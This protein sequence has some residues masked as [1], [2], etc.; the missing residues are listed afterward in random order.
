MQGGKDKGVL[1]EAQLNLSDYL[2]DEFK[3]IR[4]PLQKCVDDEAY[5]EI[6][7]KAVE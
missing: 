1:G 6:G 4:L 3:I 5:I 2:I 7:L